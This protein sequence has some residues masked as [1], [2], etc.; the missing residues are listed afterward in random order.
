MCSS[1]NSQG[2][3]G[4]E[5]HDDEGNASSVYSWKQKKSEMEKVETVYSQ[6]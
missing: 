1:G 3:K 5:L 2:H 4:R 6:L